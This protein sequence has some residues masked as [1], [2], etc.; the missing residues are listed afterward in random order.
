M[1]E[2]AAGATVAV[3]TVG[4]GIGIVEL[5][6]PDLLNAINMGLY[7]D[8]QRTFADLEDDPTT[9]VLVLTGRGR[10]FSVGADLKERKTMRPTDVRRRRE[11]APRVFGAIAH[12]R[13]PV[14]AAVAG[15]ALGGGCELAL[16]CDLIVAERDAVFGLP[17]TTLGVIPGGGATQRLPRLVGI[18]RAKELILTGRRFSSEEAE[19]FGMLSR[20]VEPG[21]AL[22]A[23]LE[24]GRGMAANPPMALFQA[25][26][27]LQMSQGLDVDRGVLF[28][29][30]AYQA[31]LDSARW[32][33]GP[34]TEPHG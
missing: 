20:V 6:R 24:L 25:K 16:A 18:Q 2:T 12:C 3:R 4:H 9:C 1:T 11:L 28:E 22:D 13:K 14:I 27:A 34:A 30:E 7:T 8:L 33:T 10:A 17:E 23:S 29:A 15:Y 21:A 31:C 26:R 32:D 19:R 5:N